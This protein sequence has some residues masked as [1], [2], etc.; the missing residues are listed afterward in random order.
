M[1]LGVDVAVRSCA[2]TLHLST[3]S[4]KRVKRQK[5]EKIPGALGNAKWTCIRCG[6]C[7]HLHEQCRA[8]TEAV[9][10]GIDWSKRRKSRKRGR[11][12]QKRTKNAGVKTCGV[13]VAR[14]TVEVSG[15]TAR[16][17]AMSETCVQ[18]GEP[19]A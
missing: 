3:T 5:S 16:D 18:E 4:T 6:G 7:D 13:A 15:G 9:I 1:V 2:A 19:Y 11:K 8:G 12:A 14:Q 10:L 17:V